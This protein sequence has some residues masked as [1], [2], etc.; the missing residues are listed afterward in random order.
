[1]RHRRAQQGL[2]LVEVLISVAIIAVTLLFLLERRT[3][4]IREALEIRRER[5]AWVLA[6]TKMAELEMD[7][8]NFTG[9]GATGDEGAFEDHEEYRFAS[10]IEKRE[11]ATNDPEKDNESPKEIFFVRLTVQGAEEEEGGALVLEAF[12]PKVEEGNDAPK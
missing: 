12:F 9:D 2:T 3:A 10:V 7:P 11:E 1:M 5:S 6:A 4:A 8:E